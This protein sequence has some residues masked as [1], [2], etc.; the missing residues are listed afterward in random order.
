MFPCEAAG[1]SGN[2]HGSGEG[3]SF[4][5]SPSTWVMSIYKMQD[6]GGVHG[7]WIYTWSL[8]GRKSS[9]SLAGG[10]PLFHPKYLII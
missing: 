6:P 2:A 8:S 1:L 5:A 9:S 10:A 4:S 7:P 3:F